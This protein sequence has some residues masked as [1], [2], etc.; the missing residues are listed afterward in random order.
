MPMI[1]IGHSFVAFGRERVRARARGFLATWLTSINE[2]PLQLTK[3]LAVVACLSLLFAG[4]PAFA[5]TEELCTGLGSQCICGEPLNTA[6][7][8]GGNAN[9]TPRELY[10]FD[11]SP[12]ATQC[13]PS[14]VDPTVEAY[15]AADFRPVSAATQPLPSGHTLSF[16][17]RQNGG[18]ICHVDNPRIVEAPG[19]TYCMRAYSRWDPASAMPDE[20]L[21]QQQKILT[22]GGSFPGW[23]MLNAQ[24]SLG[25]QSGVGELHTR[26]DGDMFASPN[27]FEVLG[28]APADCTNN[29]CRFELCFDYSSIGEGRIRM[30]RT[31]I[32]PG[33]GQVTVF[34][35]PGTILR[36]E[37][38]DLVG[39]AGN[40]L[41]M[42]AQ[43]MSVIRYNTHF[44]TTRVRPEN[45]DF[46]PG[47]ACEVEGGCSGSPSAPP[48][49]LAQSA[50]PMAPTSPPAQSAIPMAPT[51][52]LAR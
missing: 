7:H 6:T 40:G 47:P 29:F 37:G 33:S 11:D 24:I 41:S 36:P 18:G 12:P 5:G 48:P 49:P 2:R 23:D 22:L 10:N 38:L 51:S 50:I 21:G 26:F 39:G 45:R 13:Y 43:A 19:M 44:I 25:S 35:S 9:W 3:W 30:R 46:W 1:T 16:V 4:A 28:Y 20:T 15:C 42:Y 17:F 52:L 14:S 34:K 31:S 8:D 27:D 32:A